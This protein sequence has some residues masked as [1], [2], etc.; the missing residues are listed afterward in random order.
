M[1]EKNKNNG[2]TAEEREIALEEKR[3]ELERK[4]IS[5]WKDKFAL[6][7]AFFRI[8]PTP[9]EAPLLWL[10]IIGTLGGGSIKA[11]LHLFGMDNPALFNVRNA[12][13]VEAPA[14]PPP[15]DPPRDIEA[16]VE[17]SV[18]S[19]VEARRSAWRERR[20]V[21]KTATAE[22]EESVETEPVQ[23]YIVMEEAPADGGEALEIEVHSGQVVLIPRKAGV[24]RA[25]KV[26]MAQEPAG[27]SIHYTKNQ[28][29]WWER[30]HSLWKIFW[31]LFIF[32]AFEIWNINRKKK[33]A[34]KT[35]EEEVA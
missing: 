9:K 28:V 5:L 15:A 17:A 20:R 21:R 13:R 6:V 10:A 1:T 24:T 11:G 25:A 12:P 31:F 16:E 26:A 3:I 18:E 27:Y 23:N 35:S 22:A 7:G 32:G 34:K 2:S 8:L 29:D 33:K 30:S 4:K 19:T 14:P